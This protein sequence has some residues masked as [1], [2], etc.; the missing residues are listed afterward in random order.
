[1]KVHVEELSPIERKL[2]IEVE[3]T[4][5]SEELNRAYVELGRRVKIAGFRSGKIP[6]RILEQ[7]FRQEVEGDVLSR[8][9]AQAYQDAIREHR[10]EA[11]S[12]PEVTQEGFKPNAPFSFQARVEVKPQL[13]PKDYRG[14]ELK[15][16][17]V[18]VD[19]QK[20]QE[21]LEQLQQNASRLEPVER[22][23]AQSGDH[24]TIDYEATVDGKAF[25][26]S[27]AE[28]V[29]VQVVPGELVH[30]QIMALEGVNVGETKE[31]DYIFPPDYR[32][33]EVR[34]KTGHFRLQLK[35]LKV[36]VVPELNDDFA[37]EIGGGKTLEELKARVRGDLE[38][39]QQAQ[40]A[41]DERDALF[42][43]LAAKNPF[44][45]PRALVEQVLDQMAEG[46]LRMMARSGVDPRALRLDVG[47]F[48]EELREK[49]VVDV[50]GTLLLEA[51]ARKEGIQVTDEDLE[52]RMEEVAAETRQPLS[53]VRKHFRDDAQR[54]RLQA[55]L[56]EEK[57]LEFLKANATYSS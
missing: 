23:T 52:K 33:E 3:A 50:K 51:I 56:S 7:R 28:N 19:D 15:R 11:V 48:R 39:A 24:A 57:T 27:K 6:R 37:Q 31:L 2:S 18:K 10:V 1:M 14:I 29:T 25:P 12:V 38:K 42:R 26:G 16:T 44:E 9:M 36:K 55:R 54:L 32:V 22:T 13:D 49:A 43:D 21:R 5:V 20:V 34:G 47:Q 8:V 41:A 53:Q 45:V 35:G 30:G 40:Q 17:E 46:M 4:L